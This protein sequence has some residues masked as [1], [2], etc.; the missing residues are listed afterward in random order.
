MH[1]I[2]E[3]LGNAIM[4]YTNMNIDIDSKKI[5][6]NIFDLLEENKENI[7]KVNEID[8]KNNNGFKI[9]FH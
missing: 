7:E 5:V 6:Q 2:R 9:D 1:N 3:I 8:E 4:S